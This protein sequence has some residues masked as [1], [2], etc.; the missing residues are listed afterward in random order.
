MPYSGR[1][2]PTARAIAITKNNHQ[3]ALAG[4]RRTMAS[5]DAT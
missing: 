1:T 5:A 4:W 3:I 2:V